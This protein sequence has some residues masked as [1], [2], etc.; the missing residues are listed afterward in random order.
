MEP[1]FLL[2]VSA[3]LST[4]AWHHLGLNNDHRTSG[5]IA[6]VLGAALFATA[7]VDRLSSPFLIS[8]D[9]AL[10]VTAFRAYLLLWA[11]Y[12][13]V[14]AAN[15]LWGF[16]LRALG[17]HAAF[18]GV[19]SIF[20]A[21]LPFGFPKAEVSGDAHLVLTITGLTMATVSAVLFLYL[22][23]PLRQ[24]RSVTGWLL[25]AG[26]SIAGVL[27]MVVFFGV[28]ETVT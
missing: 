27:G 22:A 12:S 19:A 9:T 2:L 5:V 28:F 8:P 17:L 25:L 11:A 3:L 14:L 21:T 20:M 1:L 15:G 26:A 23:V 4:Q 10:V 13:A 7:T 6:A 24:L 16:G 18:I